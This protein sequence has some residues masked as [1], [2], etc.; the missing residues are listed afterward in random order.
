MRAVLEGRDA[1]GILPTGGGKSVC[2][3]LPA[4]LL[5]GIVLVVSPLISLMADQV[6]RARKAGLAA[7]LL[8]SGLSEAER[9]RVL[10]RATEG[11]TQLLIISPERLELPAFRAVLPRLPLSLVA[12][13]EAHC[14]SQ[15][16]H[17]FRPCY[18]R[19]GQVRGELS[20]PFLALTATATPR[21]RQEISTSLRLRDPVRVLGTF[22]RPNLAWEVRGVDGH[23]EKM[24]ALR[25]LLKRRE[26]A[27]VVYAST[28][29]AV[30]AIRRGLAA[31]GLPAL[32]YHAGLSAGRRAEV[33]RRFLGDP[34]PLVV[35]TNAFGMG[36]D[37]PDVRLV[38][39][40][41]LPGSLEAY[42]QEAGRAGRDGFDAR[43]VALFAR[44]D[45][46]VHDRFLARSYPDVRM[47]R[48]LHTRLLA[49][50]GTC[51]S[52]TIPVKD[53]CR[54][55]GKRTPEE[56]ALSALRALHRCG[57]LVQEDVDD[58]AAHASSGEGMSCRTRLTV[59]ASRPS[60]QGLTTL[61]SAALSQ[62]EAVVEYARTTECR[63]RTLL[64]Y[65]GERTGG[66][67][68]GRCDRCRDGDGRGA[69]QGLNALRALFARGAT[70]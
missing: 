47:L 37:R 15:W 33:Q 25:R 24:E 20:V 48:K 30:E 44:R 42:Y 55:M 28:R 3:Q 66:G 52:A 58:G 69:S 60:L 65:F 9:R 4:F 11:R 23:L 53:V 70:G 14:I 26:G 49:R 40:Y 38:A 7:D 31:L 1:L 18:R 22:D 2:F 13:D 6:G 54:A 68:C 34:A 8:N 61:R 51:R 29:R 41:Q 16:G 12:V 43:C 21:V 62:I 19:I 5:P 35:A 63:R 57:A 46:G 67:G 27:T 45:R 59:L 56:Q 10:A 32:T 39:H 50:L 17:D 64:A 36:I